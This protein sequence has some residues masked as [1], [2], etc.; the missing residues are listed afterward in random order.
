M[1]LVLL[2]YLACRS[3]LLGLRLRGRHALFPP[4]GE[5]EKGEKR[6]LRRHFTARLAPRRMPWDSVAGMLRRALAALAACLPMLVAVP[7][8]PAAGAP[9]YGLTIDRIAKPALIAQALAALP[10][11]PTTRVYFEPRRPPSY[12]RAALAQIH[13]VSGVMGE[14]LDSSD[15]KSIS[16]EAFQARVSSYLATLS[17]VVD[18]WEVGNEVNGNWTGPYETVAAKLTVAYREVAAVGGVSALTLYEN[19]FGP[20]H[21]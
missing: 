12:Y 13:A 7:A 8:G 6:E 15:E 11:R 17:G 5:Q 14:L 10:Q 21:C 2:L 16:T 19:D 3:S 9:L 18:I 4:E 1:S 20:E